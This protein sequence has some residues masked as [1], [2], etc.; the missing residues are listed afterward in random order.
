LIAR[1]GLDKLIPFEQIKKS[2]AL[3]LAFK[4]GTSALGALACLGAMWFMAWGLLP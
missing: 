1:W 3:V 4:Y 2:M